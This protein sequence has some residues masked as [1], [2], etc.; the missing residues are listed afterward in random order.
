MPKCECGAPAACQCRV[1]GRQ[2]VWNRVRP[3]LQD[4]RPGD[5]PRVCPCPACK[6]WR[7]LWSA[8]CDAEAKDTPPLPP[9]PES[10]GSFE[11]SL[12]QAFGPETPIIR[13]T[14]PEAP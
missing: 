12:H 2:E 13:D 8:Y 5:H 3:L 6:L 1:A 4:A 10:D 11:D 7:A 14:Q 9:L